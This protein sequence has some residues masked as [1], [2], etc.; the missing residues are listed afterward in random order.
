MNLTNYPYFQFRDRK[1]T[2]FNMRVL[3]DMSFTIPEMD[4]DFTEVEGQNKEFIKDKNRY[5]SFTKIF[6]VRLFKEEDRTIANQLR[7][8]AV[9]LRSSKDY[10]PL[11]FSEYD[12]Y[13][14]MALGYQEITIKDKYRERVDLEIS[15]KCQ[16]FIFRTDGREEQLVNQN[17]V[18]HNPEMFF[19]Q[20]KLIFERPYP[21]SR[22][23]ISINGLNFDIDAGAGSGPITM[24][25]ENGIAFDDKGKNV[26]SY[27][28]LNSQGIYT[29]MT[30]SPGDNSFYLAN[31]RNL[32]VVPRWRTL[33]V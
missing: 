32:R 19:S 7:E 25:C 11:I 6:P 4:L 16:P 12:E 33:A 8:I 22:T 29:P 20:P 13:Y 2:D 9:W 5:K 18:L 31:V 3:N 15:F 23:T 27:C 30:L 1:S 26:S 10:S 24:D 14:Y 21:N 17:S 28:F